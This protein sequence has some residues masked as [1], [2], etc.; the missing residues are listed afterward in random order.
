MSEGNQAR[1]YEILRQTEVIF[2]CFGAYD[3]PWKRPPPV[4][5][6]WGPFDRDREPKEVAGSLCGG[7]VPSVIEGMT[8]G[9]TRH[10][11]E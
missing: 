9:E 3:Q 4:E 6:H 10:R 8:R 11:G 1:Y 5:V 7:G 2:F